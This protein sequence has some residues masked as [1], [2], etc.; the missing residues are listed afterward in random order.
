L[1]SETLTVT[2]GGIALK[3]RLVEGHIQER[4]FLSLTV[5]FDHDIVDGGPAARFAHQFKELLVSG[6]GIK[7]K[8]L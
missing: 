2:I 3:P 1:S 4:E 8:M 7:E 6:Y 5:S